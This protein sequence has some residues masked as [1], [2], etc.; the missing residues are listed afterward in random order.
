MAGGSLSITQTGLQAVNTAMDA[1][2]DDLANADTNGFQSESVDFG[3]LLGGYVDGSALGGGVET[4]GITRD[5]SQGAITQTD[6]PT[7]LAIQGNGFFVFQDGSGNISYSQNGAMT[8]GSN[9]D[10]LAFNGSQVMG[11]SVSSSGATSGLLSPIVVPQ[12]ELAPTAS[13]TVALSGTLDSS[14]PVITGTI[15]PSDPS[16]YNASVSVQVYDSLGNA[17]VLTFFFQNAG[18]G[19]G[20]AAEDWNW[21]ATLDG[22]TTGLTG[23]SGTIGFSSD[24]ALV[25]GGTPTTPLTVTPAGAAPLSLSLNLGALTQYSSS[26]ALTGS[27]DGNAV[28]LPQ[29]VQ[30]SNSGLLSVSYSNGQQLNV[31]K[32]AVATFPNLQGLQLTNGGVYQQTQTSGAPTIATAGSGSAGTIEGSSLESSNVDTTSQLVNLVVLQRNYEANAK[33]LQTEDNILGDL[34]QLQTTAA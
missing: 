25:S 23:N 32:V 16:T 10:L 27:A 14:S 9:G 4:S 26:S 17:H 13:T 8:V 3:T 34:M 11:Y 19:T 12:S 33:A 24:G 28:G 20:S 30:V 5:F 29:G 18:P 21:T 1:V 7:D 31:A 6:S 15:N 22:S 2:S